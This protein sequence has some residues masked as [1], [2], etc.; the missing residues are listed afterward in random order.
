M[1][2]RGLVLALSIGAS[3]VLAGCDADGENAAAPQTSAPASTAASTATLTRHDEGALPDDWPPE[4][5]PDPGDEVWAVYLA[6]GPAGDPALA[7][8]AAYLEARGYSTY[9]GRPLACDGGAAEALFRDRDEL[10]VAAY[11]E[12]R[13]EAVDF[14]VLMKPADGAPPTPLP[15]VDLL[16]VDWDCSA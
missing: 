4:A 16:P 1:R 10:A 9:E 5:T 11:F 15:F 2:T 3:C 12:W 8:A 6:V 14:L 13:P 7:E